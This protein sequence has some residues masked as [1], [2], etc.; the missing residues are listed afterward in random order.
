MDYNTLFEKLQEHCDK[1][2]Q[3]NFFAAADLDD[4]IELNE[5]LSSFMDFYKFHEEELLDDDECDD[6]AKLYCVIDRL[7]LATFQ[8]GLRSQKM[9]T[10]IF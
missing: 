3:T 1:T 10:L 8:Q 5:L 6:L 9:D 2:C 7:L 4:L